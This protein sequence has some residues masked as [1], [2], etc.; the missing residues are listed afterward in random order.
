[1]QTSAYP[2][3]KSEGM[4]RS[5]TLLKSGN[6]LQHAF[7]RAGLTGAEVGGEA[8]KCRTIGADDLVVVTK[9]EEHMGVI[10]RRIRAHAH[11]F[12]RADLDDGNTGI[13]VEVRNDVIGDGIHLGH[14]PLS[15]KKE[16]A[17]STPDVPAL[18]A[19][20]HTDGKR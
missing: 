1:M 4:V 13:I 17:P 8:I 18:D 5:K 11:E 6:V 14:S 19:A 2:R 15:G 9:V 12:L 20:N 7:G 16:Q 10:E 3:I